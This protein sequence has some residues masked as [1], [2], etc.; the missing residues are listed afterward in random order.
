MLTPSA[1]LRCVLA[2]VTAS[3]VAAAQ[4]GDVAGEKQPELPPELALP[5]S[6]PLSADDEAKTF[7]LPP[8]LAIELVACEP[9]VEAPV[10]AVFDEDGRLWVVEMRGYMR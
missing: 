4:A 1:P 7:A 8:G 6:P 2:L 10:Q 3:S 5:A 9:L